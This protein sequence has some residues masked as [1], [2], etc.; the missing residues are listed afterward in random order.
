MS[1]AA[2]LYPVLSMVSLGGAGVTGKH[3][4]RSLGVQCDLGCSQFPEPNPSPKPVSHSGPG[5]GV[6]LS[7]T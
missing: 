3:G 2:G 4:E 6:N 1:E 7:G 5:H